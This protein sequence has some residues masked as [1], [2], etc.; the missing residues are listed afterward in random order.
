MFALALIETRIVTGMDKKIEDHARFLPDDWD[1]LAVVSNR[2]LDNTK[3]TKIVIPEVNSLKNYNRVLTDS[4]FWMLFMKYE[5]VLICH[6]DSGLLRTGIEEFLPWDYVGAPWKFQH[7]GGNGGLSL[8]NP[9]V[10]I[11]ICT[12]HKWNPGMAYEDVWY[13]N[14]M[15]G[16]YDLAPRAICEQF[17][18]ETIYRLGTL[19]YHN[20]KSYQTTSD[21]EKIINQYKL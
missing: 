19:G 17:S 16:N 13:C 4:C 1:Q 11:E 15:M 18:V 12:K 5:R 2:S 20:I 6:M 21:V 9:N 8:R 3:K 14:Y 10:M 7:N